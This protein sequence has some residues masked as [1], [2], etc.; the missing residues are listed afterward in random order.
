VYWT[1]LTGGN[2]VKCAAGGCNS[3]PTVLASNQPHPLPLAVDTNNTVYWGTDNSCAGLGT[4]VLKCAGSSAGCTPTLVA[5]GLGTP[6]GIAVDST[7]VYWTDTT[8]N[9]V[10]KLTPK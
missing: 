1:Q 9:Q 3:T 7:S 6:S 4:V 8:L 5:S 10:M 2:V